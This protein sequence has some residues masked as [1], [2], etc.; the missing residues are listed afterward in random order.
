I[1]VPAMNRTRGGLFPSPGQ[2]PTARLPTAPG[3]EY[4]QTSF[5]LSASSAN[6]RLPPG[7]YMIPLMTIGVTSGESPGAPPRPFPLPAPAAGAS[8]EGAGG[9][10]LKVHATFRFATFVVLICFSGENRSLV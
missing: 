10:G 4:V 7:R 9:A 5:P 3:A 2:Y 1:L 6:T 8:A